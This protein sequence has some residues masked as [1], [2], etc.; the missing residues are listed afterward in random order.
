MPE[1]YLDDLAISD[2]QN[3]EFV[4]IYQGKGIEKSKKS[5]TLSMEFRR[6]SETLTHQQVDEYQQQI[7]TV[8]KDK[9]NAE[10]R[11]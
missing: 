7:L 10:L 6:L 5:L 9:F 2:L 1:L 8:L 11:A 3:L 4:G